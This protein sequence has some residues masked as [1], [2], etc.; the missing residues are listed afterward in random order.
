MP[1]AA[2]VIAPISDPAALLFRAM[3]DRHVHEVRAA[4]AQER[5]AQTVRIAAS[6]FELSGSAL[7][8]VW[9]VEAKHLERLGRAAIADYEQR[10]PKKFMTWKHFGPVMEAVTKTLKGEAGISLCQTRTKRGEDR[11]DV[12]R[13]R[14]TIVLQVE[15]II[16]AQLR[17]A[18]FAAE[19]HKDPLW[20]RALSGLWEL[21]KLA[22]G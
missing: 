10:A 11:A 14:A 22:R 8:T 4:L 1:N 13:F 18:V 9:A 16:E 15:S 12:E 20:K 21:A 19:A 17:A 7:H 3:W 5:G 2:D 6:N